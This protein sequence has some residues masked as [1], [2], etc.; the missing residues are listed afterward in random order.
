MVNVERSCVALR[1]GAPR[2]RRRGWNR[3][4]PLRF[5]SE[6]RACAISLVTIVRT[7][8]LAPPP[9]SSASAVAAGGGG[10]AANASRPS[11]AKA[12][13]ASASGGGRMPPIIDPRGGTA[14]VVVRA[15]LQV[16]ATVVSDDVLHKDL[17]S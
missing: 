17:G 13:A 3:R 7:S 4:R 16:L 12:A 10:A 11:S 9:P 1:I 6:D 8:G 14:R 15:A 2:R 5:L